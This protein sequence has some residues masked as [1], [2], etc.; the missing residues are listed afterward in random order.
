MPVGGEI[1]E[2]NDEVVANVQLLSDDP[3]GRG[4]LIKVR[5]DDPSTLSQLLDFEA[6]EKQVSDESH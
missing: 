2:L 5:I 6:Y 1:V 3:F 4:W